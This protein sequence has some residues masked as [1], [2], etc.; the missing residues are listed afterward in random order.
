MRFNELYHH[1]LDQAYYIQEFEQ[2]LHL[3]SLRLPKQER[4]DV[5]EI[6][7]LAAVIQPDPALIAY[8]S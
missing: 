7:V 5:K 3:A 4:Q 2:P 8:L 6:A 1:D